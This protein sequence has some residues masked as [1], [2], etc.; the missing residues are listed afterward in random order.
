MPHVLE[1]LAQAQPSD[2]SNGSDWLAIGLAIV[3]AAVA[4]VG[5][6]VSIL[7]YRRSGRAEEATRRAEQRDLER[8]ERERHEVAASK[9]ARLELTPH[10]HSY[11]YDDP[12]ARV[13]VRN[14][15]PAIANDVRVW[16]VEAH[17]DVAASE[18]TGEITLGVDRES[19]MLGVRVNDG[20]AE[21]DMH[22]LRWFV[23][24]TDD[25]EGLHQRD[26]RRRPP[27]VDTDPP[28]IY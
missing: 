20:I 11:Q 15:G 1:L 5:V 13:T 26:A 9:R 4:V 7:A 2:S 28:T 27:V 19:E 18:F 12:V 14:F 6:V 10:A 8:L 16:L 24:W 21:E 17:R 25:E 22:M 3:A 23:E